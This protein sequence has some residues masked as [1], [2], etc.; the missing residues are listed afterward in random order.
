MKRSVLIAS[1]LG[2]V[3]IIVGSVVGGI[4]LANRSD[5]LPPPGFIP[6]ED[7]LSRASDIPTLTEDEIARA[8]EIFS[9]DPRTAALLGGLQY[10]ITDIGPWLRNSNEKIG[11]VMEVSINPPADIDGKWPLADYDETQSP[12]PY[13][14]AQFHVEV[15]GLQR[16]HV[17]VDL[18]RGKLVAID[19]YRYSS[20]IPKEEIPQKPPSGD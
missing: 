20:I 14:E 15:H 6:A 8:K 1:F 17:L 12:A 10:T 9:K 11:A 3:G 18:V 16:V 7:T 5:N 4:V 13:R 19:P 2:V